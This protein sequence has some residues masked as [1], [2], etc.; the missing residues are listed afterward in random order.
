[1]SQVLIAGSGNPV[2]F[3]AKT[4]PLGTNAGHSAQ[5][6]SIQRDGTALTQLTTFTADSLSSISVSDDGARIV[7]IHEGDPLA[8][9]ADLGPEL[10]AIDG[11]GMNLRQL[12]TTPDTFNTG[13]ATISGD[14]STIA[15]TSD[16][17][18]TGGNLV[19]Q[20][21]IF[22]IDWNGGA[23]RQVT[24]TTAILSFTG[25]PSADGPSIVDDG[26]R[27]FYY[28]NF[29]S[30]FVNLDSNFEIFSISSSGTGR[31]QITSSLLD[32]G[33]VLPVVSGD[34]SRVTYLDIS[35][36]IGI[37]TETVPGG[38]TLSLAT[39]DVRLLS[40]PDLSSDRS[41][42]VFTRSTGLFSDA[43]VWK[44]DG[45]GGGLA[46][47]TSLSG[48]GASSPSVVGDGQ[49]LIFGSSADPLGL[50]ID[51]SDEIFLINI[52]G[53]GLQQLTAFPSGVAAA[54]ASLSDDGMKIVFEGDAD[55][56]GLNADGST[57]LFTM[58]VDGSALSQLTDG[59]LGTT[60]RRAQLDASGL[61]V[62]FE[63]N[64]DFDGGNVDGSYEVWRVQSGG[65]GLDR[66]TGDPL[67]GSADADIS[68]DG[69]IIVYRSSADPLGT[70]PENNSEIYI[71]R[72]L[73][74]AL[75]QLTSFVEGGVSAPALDRSGSWVYF[76]TSAPI[77]EDDPDRPSELYRIP[78]AGGPIERVG[79]LTAG[80][81]SAST[82]GSSD[83]VAFLEGLG[84]PT[85]GNADQLPEL[86]LIDRDTSP[87]ISVSAVAPTVVSWPVPS[88]PKRF[89]VIRGDVAQLALLPDLSVDLGA[90]AC[91]ENDSPD[92][93]TEVAPDTLEPLPGQV[94]F[95]LYRGSQGILDGPGSYGLGTAG[96][97]RSASGDC[98][99]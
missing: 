80:S 17:D 40:D 32:V 38:V 39:T 27:I 48:G 56:N 37:V 89:D 12:T 83:A 20:T 70:N 47:V 11:G 86:W 26:S 10:F 9:N 66:L 34:G 97:E 98:S 22:A 51:A 85:G 78:A 8:T 4:D 95:Y 36:Q 90:V 61:W 79:A 23:L 54:D 69:T 14:G 53:S 3:V 87:V 5:L 7:L 73:T 30:I 63:S 93:D 46:Q 88:G 29:S 45:D 68:A 25:D 49:T 41:T 59:L 58:N 67:F 43:Q 15:F 55:P 35:N 77:F 81:F 2:L 18:L 28:S 62:V 92:T 13:S 24:T 71:Y 57:E 65:G 76:S 1:M 75:Q 74:A 50:N 19:A 84:D 33:S 21:E 72:P 91:L 94:L 96:G 60:S 82:L 52:D 64:A 6:F 31:T 44:V 99:Q 16:A 42:A